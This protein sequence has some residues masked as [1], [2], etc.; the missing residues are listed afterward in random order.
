MWQTTSLKMHTVPQPNQ[1]RKLYVVIEGM[2]KGPFSFDELREMTYQNIF[3]NDTLYWEEGMAGWAPVGAL[4]LPPGSNQGVGRIRGT[5]SNPSDIPVRSDSVALHL[6]SIDKETKPRVPIEARLALILSLLLTW[7]LPIISAGIPTNAGARRIIVAWCIYL[8]LGGPALFCGH[9][10][11][12]KIRANSDLTG[13]GRSITGLVI[14][15]LC[16]LIAI[17]IT[18]YSLD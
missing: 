15:Y 3:R 8:A 4:F 14:A 9:R 7:F 11:I 2:Q 12:S 17:L 13:I 16:S 10:A 1:T 5:V 6:D 18:I